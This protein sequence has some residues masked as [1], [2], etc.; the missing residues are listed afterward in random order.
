[1][2][3]E[4]LPVLTASVW[5]AILDGLRREGEI[6][7]QDGP[8]PVNKI[9]YDRVHHAYLQCVPHAQKACQNTAGLR[10]IV[11]GTFPEWTHPIP[12]DR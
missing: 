9:L 1:M 6:F 8:H 11:E 12:E 4:K 7:V 3:K 10:G 2:T 5:Y